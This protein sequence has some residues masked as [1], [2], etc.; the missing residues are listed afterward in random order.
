MPMLSSNTRMTWA[1][2][3]TLLALIALLLFTGLAD[4]PL[5]THA[6]SYFRDNADACGRPVASGLYFCLDTPIITHTTKALLRK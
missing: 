3:G 6:G 5:D 2:Y 4:L 1:I